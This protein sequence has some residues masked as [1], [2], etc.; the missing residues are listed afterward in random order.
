MTKVVVDV[1]QEDLESAVAFP[2]NSLLEPD[3]HITYDSLP[4]IKNG[5]KFQAT[6]FRQH[7]QFARAVLALK[8]RG[9]SVITGE[10]NA[11]L[12]IR[13]GLDS[14]ACLNENYIVEGILCLPNDRAV[15]V[16]TLDILDTTKINPQTPY[17][18][19][20]YPYPLGLKSRE[21]QEITE[22][23]QKISIKKFRR[24]GTNYYPTKRQVDKILSG[25]HLILEEETVELP[26]ARLEDS[27]VARYIFGEATG[28]YGEFLDSSGIKDVKFNIFYKYLLDAKK[29]A[30]FDGSRPFIFPLTLNDV[31]RRSS[32]N[33]HEIY[34]EW[35]KYIISSINHPFTSTEPGIVRG[36]K[37]KE[38]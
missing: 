21:K 20:I 1:R 10:E 26:S 12:R 22:K 23:E 5:S 31:G 38:K 14:I 28:Q 8:E 25:K 13:E 11:R 34:T 6:A 9:F 4:K 3:D 2:H 29:G 32:E 15:L 18:G 17:N 36:I 24:D 7:D 35:G 27:E 16:S 19:F 30:F 33:P 37:Y